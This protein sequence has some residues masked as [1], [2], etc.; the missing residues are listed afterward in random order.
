[1]S[2]LLYAQPYD[3]SAKGFYFDD[4][5]TF[6]E[7]VKTCRNDYGQPVE[8]FEIQFIEGDRIDCA[9][10]GTFELNQCNFAKFFELVDEWEDDNKTRF[11]IAVGECGF[12]F[13]LETDSPDDLDIDVYDVQSLRE[14]AEQ[15]VDEGL[16]GDIP[17][18]LEFYIDYDAM[19]RDLAVDYSMTE[20]AGERL[21]YR[22]G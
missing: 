6:Y 18:S 16:Y 19:A 13:N 10:S 9:F 7:K 1:M 11:I 5:D 22:C 8:E 12:K 2:L 21:A 20:I 15:F 4:A 14:L 17:K 3:T